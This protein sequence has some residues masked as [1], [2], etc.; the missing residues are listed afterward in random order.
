[1][2]HCEPKFGEPH[3][4]LKPAECLEFLAIRGNI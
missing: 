3:T 4:L 2:M 1:M